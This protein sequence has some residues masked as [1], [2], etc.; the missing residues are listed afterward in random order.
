[1]ALLP[2]RRF[3][4]WLSAPHLPIG[5]APMRINLPCLLIAAIALVAV[6]TALAS[7]ADAP[8]PYATQTIALPGGT[9]LERALI[10]GP[11]R[12]PAGFER[13]AVSPAPESTAA[14]K[15]LSVPAYEWSFGCSATSG[16]MIAAY[17]DRSGW[18]NIYTGPA[19]GG[20][21]PTD[22]S[23]W[24]YWTD[25]VGDRYAQCPL[26]ATR[27]GLD[28]RSTRGSIDDYWVEYG[29]SASDPYITQ[30]W[31]QHAHGE[32]IG[33]YMKTSQSEYG[34]VDGATVFY[35]W[36]SSSG[37]F[38]CAD[39]PGYGADDDGSYGRKLFYEA[40]GYTVTTCYNQKTSNNGGGFTFAMYKAEI[41][42]G[43]PVMLN[44]AGHT[45]VGIGY[46][47]SGSKVYIHDTWDFNTY[48]MS[49]GGSYEGMAMQ[50]VSIVNIA[51]PAAG[52]VTGLAIAKVNNSEVMLTWPAVSGAA[53]YEIWSAA[54][55]PYFTPGGNCASPAP[56][57]CQVV[58]GTS[59]TT[60][61]LGSAANNYTYAAKAL[62]ACGGAS[63]APSNRAAEFEFTL[64]RP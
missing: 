58:T 49:W 48:S 37:P 35:N 64:V 56:Y 3:L 61:A 38:H 50:S 41:D 53:Q 34:N 14:S 6:S 21:M 19:N 51:C 20:V 27:N 22:S 11:P 26:A 28:G 54:N 47:D 1:M 40:R 2:L 45:V 44:L 46:D 55:Q 7:A 43:R 59:L 12:P 39:M 62:N 25:G 33:D 63:A 24:G 9:T 17:Y 52:N 15:T 4:R 32:A 10:V 31:T 8:P 29:S 60:V 36:S 13:V 18:P 57:A 30:G 16:A 23:G 42:A 5:H